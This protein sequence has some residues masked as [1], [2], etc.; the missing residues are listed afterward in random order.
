LSLLIAVLLISVAA[1]IVAAAEP[2]EITYSY[3]VRLMKLRVFKQSLID[4]MPN[5]LRSLSKV[6]AIPN[7]EYVTN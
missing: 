7:E 5:I 1:S 3:W 6:M 2:D 4:S